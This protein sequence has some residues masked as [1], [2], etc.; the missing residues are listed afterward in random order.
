[1]NSW[2]TQ[3]ESP[4][5][6]EQLGQLFGSLCRQGLVALLNGDLG[7]GKTHFAKGVAC[8]LDVPV[9]VVVTSPSY[10]LLNVYQGRFPLYHFDLYRLAKVD[11]LADLGYDEFAE[12]DGVTLVEWADRMGDA[13]EASLAVTIARISDQQRRIDFTG[14]DSSGA[15]LVDALAQAWSR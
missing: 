9:E 4:E 3:T 12:G 8:G 14:I 15:K 2:H 10:T 13:L 1:M 5:Q 6:T 11:D 7:A